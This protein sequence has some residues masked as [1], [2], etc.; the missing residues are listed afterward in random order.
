MMEIAIN[1]LS[2]RV[3]LHLLLL[4]HILMVVTLTASHS[5]S[6]G[7]EWKGLGGFPKYVANSAYEYVLADQLRHSPFHEMAMCSLWCLTFY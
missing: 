4:H 6:G 3:L 2:E 5:E 7:A 1:F